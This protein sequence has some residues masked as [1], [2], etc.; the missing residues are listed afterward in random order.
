MVPG[1]LRIHRPLFRIPKPLLARGNS[2][3]SVFGNSRACGLSRTRHGSKQ[4]APAGTA[5]GSPL[6]GKNPFQNNARSPQKTHHSR[7][8][9]KSELES[10]FEQQNHFEPLTRRHHRE[11]QSP[12]TPS[13]ESTRATKTLCERATTPST[14]PTTPECRH[15]SRGATT[16]AS[17]TT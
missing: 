12:A 11:A 8:G 10:L 2:G 13:S 6:L 15:G 4:R 14:S 9:G 7:S 5:R 3:R 17:W 1:G 16:S